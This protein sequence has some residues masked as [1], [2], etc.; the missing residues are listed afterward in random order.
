MNYLELLNFYER[1]MQESAAKASL[2]VTAQTRRKYEAL[3]NLYASTIFYLDKK[4]DNAKT[5]G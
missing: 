2:A 1:K 5:N 3:A 4:N